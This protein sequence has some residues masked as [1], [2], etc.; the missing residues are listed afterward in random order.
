M[1]YL[2]TVELKS[3]DIRRIDITS[4]TSATH[5]LTWT[6]PNEQSLIVTINGVKQQNNYTVSG[7]TLTL[8]TALSA[9]D[10]LEVIGINDIGT[11]ITPAQGSV[12]TDQLA[13]D[14]VTSAKIAAGT[15]ATADIADDAVDAD[16]LAN[17]INTE[18][19]ANTAKV[20]NATHTGDVTGATALTIAD[21]V[22]TA[23]KLA[24]SAYLANRNIVINGAMAVAQRNTTETGITASGYS[25]CDRY[26]FSLG[27]LGTWTSAQESLTSGDAYADGFQKAFRVDCT[28]ADA[29]PS[30]ADYFVFQQKIEGYDVQALKKGTANAESVTLSFWVKSSTTGTYIFGL[31]DRDNTRSIWQSYTISSADTWEKKTLTFSGDTTGAFGC[32]NGASLELWWYLGAGTDYTS[33]TLQTSWGAN[34][35]ANTAVG[36]VN[37]AASTSNDWAITG[38]QLEIGT[39]AT[40]FE[41]KIY[42]R[43]LADCQRY[44]QKLYSGQEGPLGAYVDSTKIY[45]Y[46]YPLIVEMRS[47]PTLDQGSSSPS[48]EYRYSG[49]QTDGTFSSLSAKTMAIRFRLSQPSAVDTWGIATAIEIK[50]TW[51]VDSEL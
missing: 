30:A 38:V 47:A 42:G 50:G 49:W 51:S 36:Q 31:F 33:G 34:V 43:E 35:W 4:S 24:D 40:P 7:T 37:L 5:T 14:A 15:I 8:D 13:N 12:D 6:A 10:L 27:T 48:F 39:T 9:S 32:D 41:H 22:V 28:T 44:Y 20:T 2:G 18:I 17:S 3:S 19:A 21:D 29:S 23:A 1:P 45:S 26:R 16:K 25:T 46:F 11:T